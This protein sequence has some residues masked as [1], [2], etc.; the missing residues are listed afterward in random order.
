MVG[1][2]VAAWCGL[3]GLTLASTLWFADAAASNANAD[4]SATAATDD[5]PSA[6]PQAGDAPTTPHAARTQPQ[7]GDIPPDFLGVDTTGAAIKVSDYRGK[8]VVVTFWASW[9]AP[10]LRELPMLS[11]LQTAVGREHLQVVAIN[12]NQP[13]SDFEQFLRLNGKLDLTYIHDPGTAARH[14]AVKTV[15]NLF[16]IDRNGAIVRVHRGY[17]TQMVEQFAKELAS[18]LPPEALK[19]PA[20]KRD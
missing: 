5:R 16:V 6:S 4:G 20:R 14:Y 1:L 19:Q 9:C 18:L 3:A 17:S 10:C 15:P 8:L 11:A 12:L 13:K 7:P 2:R